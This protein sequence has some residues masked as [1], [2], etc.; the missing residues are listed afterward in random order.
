MVE[1]PRSVI[2]YIGPAAHSDATRC[3]DVLRSHVAQ[4]GSPN[5][6]SLL[7]SAPHSKGGM[8]K[9]MSWMMVLACALGG[10][11]PAVGLDAAL[12]DH[13]T[14]VTD[15][16]NDRLCAVRVTTISEPLLVS[17]LQVWLTSASGTT[18]MAF[19]V[20]DTNENRMLDA[21]ETVTVIEPP[22]N[23]V[24]VAQRG[25]VFSIEF[26]RDLGSSR[27]SSLWEGDWTAQ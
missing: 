20:A 2:G 8:M 5:T 11:G 18:V 1:M 24:G 21:G 6:A 25:T 9:S 14:E 13:T 22:L 26:V 23:V 15:A 17:E 27:V 7:R 12:M 10:C 19:E 16:A 3:A 4:R